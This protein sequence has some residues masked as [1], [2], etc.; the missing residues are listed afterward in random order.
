ML[1]LL[2][3]ARPGLFALI[4]YPALAAALFDQFQPTTLGRAEG[5]CIALSVEA[6][7]VLSHSRARG[8][9]RTTESGAHLPLSITRCR[10]FPSNCFSFPVPQRPFRQVFDQIQRTGDGG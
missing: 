3:G 5:V 10:S 2:A 6:V 4:V 7:R 8:R 1:V 9:S